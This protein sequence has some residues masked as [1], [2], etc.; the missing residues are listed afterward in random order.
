MVIVVKVGTN[1]LEP[2]G[3]ITHLKDDY[4]QFSISYLQNAHLGLD[5]ILY[6]GYFIYRINKTDVKK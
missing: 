3:Q 6:K 1:K 4:P 2:Y 5:P